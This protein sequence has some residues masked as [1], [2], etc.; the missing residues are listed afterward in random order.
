[1]FLSFLYLL[2]PV[3]IIP[4]GRIA[5][6]HN[7]AIVSTKL[8]FRTYPQFCLF[9]GIVGV[10]GLL[11]DMIIVLICMLHVAAIYR[12]TLVNRHGG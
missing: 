8:L 12:S 6:L 5:L 3:D 10:I 2:S 7:L 9:T 11:D 4:E 1:M